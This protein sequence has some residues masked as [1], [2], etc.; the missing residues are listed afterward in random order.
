MSKLGAAIDLLLSEERLPAQYRDHVLIGQY[1]GKRECHI[2][3]DW[4]LIY[5]ITDG[6][7][8]EH[9]HLASSSGPREPAREHPSRT[10]PFA[11]YWY[12]HTNTVNAM[13][14]VGC[15]SLKT[16]SSEPHKRGF[17]TVQFARLEGLARV[18]FGNPRASR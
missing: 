8:T 13:T 6:K 7:L 2:S 4:L 11:I 15:S 1:F 9:R 17:T 5:R 3:P 16:K 14:F 12:V 10:S 18:P